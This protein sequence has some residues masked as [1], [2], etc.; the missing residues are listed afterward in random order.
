MYGFT[1]IK[2]LCGVHVSMEYLC[3]LFLCIQERDVKAE[4]V[5]GEVA[6]LAI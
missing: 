3:S 6:R 5:L 4:Q 1:G 2:Y